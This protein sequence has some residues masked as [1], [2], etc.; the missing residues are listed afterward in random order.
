MTA[1]EACTF[2]L[3]SPTKSQPESP[4]PTSSPSF[5]FSNNMTGTSESFPPPVSHVVSLPHF[6]SAESRYSNSSTAPPSDSNKSMTTLVV[7]SDNKMSDYQPADQMRPGPR[8]EYDSETRDKQLN[9]LTSNNAATEAELTKDQAICHPYPSAEAL[10][11]TAMA[12]C[13]IE[14]MAWK[15]VL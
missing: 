6:P 11:A 12:A 2:D 5:E 8:I 7:S 10:A 1:P 3:G 14:R 9:M 15:S 4:A 13:S